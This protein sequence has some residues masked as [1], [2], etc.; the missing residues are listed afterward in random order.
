MAQFCDECDDYT[1]FKKLQTV[2][3]QLG[4]C[5]V[6][7]MSAFTSIAL[8]LAYAEFKERYV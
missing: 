2:F 5:M 1:M 7:E 4:A 6:L 8:E 3:L